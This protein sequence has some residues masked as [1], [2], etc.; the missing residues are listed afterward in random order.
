LFAQ[1]FNGVVHDCHLYPGSGLIA[2]RS[3]CDDVGALEV[4]AAVSFLLMI[5]R[6]VPVRPIESLL[7]V[8]AQLTGRAGAIVSLVFP[9]PVFITIAS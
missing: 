1:I 4:A 3:E 2:A 9:T 7:N 8:A 5:R 6:S